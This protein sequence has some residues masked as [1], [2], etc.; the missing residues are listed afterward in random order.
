MSQSTSYRSVQDIGDEEKGFPQEQSRKQSHRQTLIP[1]DAF[2]FDARNGDPNMITPEE[3]QR[4]SYADSIERLRYQG[5]KE[6]AGIELITV[7]ALGSEFTKEEVKAMKKPYKRKRKAREAGSNA[8]KWVKSDNRYF[9]CL[10]PIAAVF[11][12]FFSLGW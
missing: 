11:T 9:G 5:T 2:G 7:P 3:H 10:S 4:Y 1:S 12:I 6:A 8:R